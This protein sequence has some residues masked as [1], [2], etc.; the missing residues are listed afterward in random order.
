[1]EDHQKKHKERNAKIKEGEDANK[2]RNKIFFDEVDKIIDQTI[3]QYITRAVFDEHDRDNGSIFIVRSQPRS[4]K[5]R[6]STKTETF[7]D[8]IEIAAR[9]FGFEPDMVFLADKPENG[10]IYLG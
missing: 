10:C 4:L 6:C 2:Q 8:V 1:M 5:M 3:K 7:N 9:Y